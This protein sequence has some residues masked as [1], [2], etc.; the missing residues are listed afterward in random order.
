MTWNLV[1]WIF[2]A[3]L[4]VGGV[5]GF[6]KAKSRASLIASIGSAIPLALTAAGILPFVVAPVVLGALLVVFVLRLIK[7]RKFMPSG[8]LLLLTLLTAAAVLALRPQA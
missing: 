5:I 3:L 8:M 2:T 4:V 6:L 1:V 7:T